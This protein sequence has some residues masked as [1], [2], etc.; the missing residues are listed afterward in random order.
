LTQ[1]LTPEELTET[2][3]AQVPSL[4]AR[5][6]ELEEGLREIADSESPSGKASYWHE[7]CRRIARSALNR[8]T[9]NGNN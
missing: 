3:L 9:D 7:E 5:I 2:V 1:S 6:R 4:L 8:S